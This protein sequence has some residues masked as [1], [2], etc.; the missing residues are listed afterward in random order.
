MKYLLVLF[1]LA[2]AAPASAG[3]FVEPYVGY[4]TGHFEHTVTVNG[5]TFQRI[6]T[7]FS[8]MGFGA[9]AGFRISALVFG[10][11]YQGGSMNFSGAGG[12]FK[13]KDLGAFAGLFLPGGLRLWG[14]YFFKSKSDSIEGSGMKGGI[15]YLF[16][17]HLSLNVEYITYTF[18]TISLPQFAGIAIGYSGKASALM[19]SLSMP[20]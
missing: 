19:F 2:L 18:K 11:E 14:T 10:G 7:D 4:A 5:T 15:G 1:S 6:D 9:R 17:K 16:M 12:G 8:G 3:V 13:P 20:F